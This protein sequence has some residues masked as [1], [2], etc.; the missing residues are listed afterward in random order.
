[1]HGRCTLRR[2]AVVCHCLAVAGSCWEACERRWHTGVWWRSSQVCT[3]SQLVGGALQCCRGQSPQAFSQ[4]LAQHQSL[5]AGCQAPA[6][7]VHEAPLH[8]AWHTQDRLAANRPVNGA[9]GALRA[10]DDAAA[11]ADDEA[12]DC[13]DGDGGGGGGDDDDADDDEED[14]EDEDEDADDDEYAYEYAVDC[15]CDWLLN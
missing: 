13:C 8:Q 9:A 6:L 12:G 3:L 10:D 11:A 5:K 15:D 1:M 14:D 2:T 4:A 7:I